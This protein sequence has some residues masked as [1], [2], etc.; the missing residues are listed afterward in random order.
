[1]MLANVLPSIS[2][3]TWV[4]SYKGLINV[5]ARATV[6]SYVRSAR[7]FQVATDHEQVM[8]PMTF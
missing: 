7:D 2:L 1:M 6:S 4:T 5:D 3:C 8:S